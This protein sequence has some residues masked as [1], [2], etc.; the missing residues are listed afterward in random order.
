MDILKNMVTGKE[1]RIRFM[2]KDPTYREGFLNIAA[3]SNKTDHFITASE[4][5][6]RWVV[7]QTNPTRLT[8]NPAFPPEWKENYKSEYFAA[9]E[10]SMEENDCE[11]LKTLANYLYNLNLDSF[12]PT[13]IPV[14]S[15]LAQQ[16]YSSLSVTK[17]WYVECINRQYLTT[18][19]ADWIG[20]YGLEKLFKDFKSEVVT[21]NGKQGRIPRSF[22]DFFD[23]IKSLLPEESQKLTK[24]HNI[25]TLVIPAYDICVKALKKAVPGIE[26]KLV[27][28]YMKPKQLD[29]PH[30][31][32]I[33]KP[34]FAKERDPFVD[35]QGSCILYDSDYKKKREEDGTYRFSA[36]VMKLWYKRLFEYPFCIPPDL[37][38]LS[39]KSPEYL[40]PDEIGTNSNKLDPLAAMKRKIAEIAAKD[41]R[42]EPAPKKVQSEPIPFPVDEE[43]D[44]SLPVDPIADCPECVTSDFVTYKG[45]M[46][47]APQFMCANCN[48]MFSK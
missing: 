23:E 15:A 39:V 28:S 37:R 46:M 6:R 42:D 1:Q 16:R 36:A 48:T 29:S 7:L 22:M 26:Y 18:A 33:P 27:D 17:A 24:P 38:V 20:S 2:R 19:N 11:G 4:E 21:P 8:S 13:D 43:L 47:E 10:Q 40:L 30:F 34:E 25:P 32:F 44:P 35:L 14:S 9:I 5:S 12:R 41:K 31:Q 45:I 3:S